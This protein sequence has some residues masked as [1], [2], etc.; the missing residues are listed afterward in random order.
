MPLWSFLWIKEPPFSPVHWY[1]RNVFLVCS[2]VLFGKFVHWL[3]SIQ[4]FPDSSR[5]D[6]EAVHLTIVIWLFLKVPLFSDNDS[7]LP[8]L[9]S[10]V[11]SSNALQGNDNRDQSAD[12][13]TPPNCSISLTMKSGIDQCGSQPDLPSLTRLQA[14]EKALQYVSSIT[15]ESTI[16]WLD[17]CRYP[18]TAKRW[19]QLL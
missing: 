7:D 5:F 8:L 14:M 10:I 19:S 16:L 3:T 2:L 6:W 9:Q 11:L 18:S 15:L 13:T 1:R 12:S 17:P 4:I